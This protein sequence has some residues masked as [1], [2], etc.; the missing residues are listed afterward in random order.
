MPRIA[1]TSRHEINHNAINTKSILECYTHQESH[2]SNSKLA[3][4][5][6]RFLNLFALQKSKNYLGVNCNYNGEL[7]HIHP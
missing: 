1:P 5:G 6:L 2:T 4:L 3:H 7:F